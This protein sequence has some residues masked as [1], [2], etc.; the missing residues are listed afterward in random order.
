MHGWSPVCANET[1]LRAAA[2]QLQDKILVDCTNHV[3]A[4][5]SYGHKSVR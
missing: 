5:L 3:D 2:T 1:A 4:D